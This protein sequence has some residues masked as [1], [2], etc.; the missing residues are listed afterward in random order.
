M[1]LGTKLVPP[2]TQCKFRELSLRIL[3]H[4]IKTYMLVERA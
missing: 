1:E 4:Y 3:F 2:G